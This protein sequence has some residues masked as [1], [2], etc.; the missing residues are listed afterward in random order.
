[1]EKSGACSAV[2]VHH[3]AYK[4]ARGWFAVFGQ[5]NV[6]NV[7]QFREAQF[8]KFA[9]GTVVEILVDVSKVTSA[10]DSKFMRRSM[11]PLQIAEIHFCYFRR[12]HGAKRFIKY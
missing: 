5:V 10:N 8:N 2:T 11:S 3:D 4:C 6:F 1:M 12:I 7:S 9:L